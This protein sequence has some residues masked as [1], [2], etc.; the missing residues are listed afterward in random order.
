MTFSLVIDRILTVFCLSLLLSLR[1]YCKSHKLLY[2]VYDPFLAEKPLF[3]NKTFLH[4]TVLTP[5]FTQ[6]ILCNASDNIRPTSLNIGGRM[7]GPRPH[8]K[9]W[10]DRP[11]VSPKSPSM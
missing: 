9:F 2:D 4:D 6:F 11:P 8:L 7:C 1:L 3:Q 5:L 10:G